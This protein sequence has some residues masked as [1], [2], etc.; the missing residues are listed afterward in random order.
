MRPLAKRERQLPRQP[1]LVLLFCSLAI[2]WPFHL[3][4]KCYTL[5][6]IMM[7]IVEARKFCQNLIPAKSHLLQ[8]DSK[9][10]N[11]FIITI[12]EYLHVTS[13]HIPGKSD[14][15]F[16]WKPEIVTRVSKS[17]HFLLKLLLD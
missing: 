14:M 10:E 13:V 6:D 11:D 17:V 12:L 4:G 16:S 1:H 5:S 8:I 2:V 7:P 3:N 9:E 15:K